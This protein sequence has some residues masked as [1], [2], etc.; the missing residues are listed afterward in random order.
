MFVAGEFVAVQPPVVGFQLQSEN[1][2]L[3]GRHIHCQ[4]T[5]HSTGKMSVLRHQD[6]AILCVCVCVCSVHRLRRPIARSED[7]PELRR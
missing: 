3:L 1:S 7:C 4:G 6:V 5:S 2:D